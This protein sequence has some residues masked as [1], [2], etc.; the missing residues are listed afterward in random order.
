MK[1]TLEK[2]PVATL[3]TRRMPDEDQKLKESDVCHVIC[4]YYQ[5]IRF[6]K[7]I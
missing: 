2:T 4:F 3:K 5:N 6:L 1:K 7:Y